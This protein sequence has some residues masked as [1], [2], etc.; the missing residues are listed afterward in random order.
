MNRSD[1]FVYLALVAAWLV[2][3]AWVYRIGRKANR[4][5]ATMDAAGLAPHESR[6]A[7]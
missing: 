2:I 4:L 1:L 3:A 7:F 6:D 5:Q